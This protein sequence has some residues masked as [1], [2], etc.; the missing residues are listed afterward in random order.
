MSSPT[1]I[2]KLQTNQP[3]AYLESSPLAQDLCP[4]RHYC[5]EKKVSRPGYVLKKQSITVKQKRKSLKKLSWQNTQTQI[6][7]KQANKAK[8]LSGT[9]L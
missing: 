8:K 3:T 4:A 2:T 6:K 5:M 1:Q 7:N 9:R